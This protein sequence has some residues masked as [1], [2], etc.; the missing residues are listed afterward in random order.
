MIANTVGWNS[1]CLRPLGTEN[2]IQRNC[3]RLST[4]YHQHQL[5]L[6]KAFSAAGLFITN[7]RSK[8]SD[9]NNDCFLKSYFM[10][11]FLMS[12]HTL[13]LN[14][15]SH[16]TFLFTMSGKLWLNSKYSTHISVCGLQNFHCFLQLYLNT[17][18]KYQIFLPRQFY[19][20][21]FQN[22]QL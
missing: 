2:R 22:F 1:V 11:K 13:I 3:S 21:P 10:T 4:L 15:L 8:L 17:I 20:R 19:F 6:K 9:H 12:F 5:K 14:V 18:E 16:L 7:L